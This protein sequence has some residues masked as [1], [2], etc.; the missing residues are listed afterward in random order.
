MDKASPLFVGD[1]L[2]QNHS[3]CVLLRPGRKVGKQRFIPLAGECGPRECRN[4]VVV[5][6]IFKIK[7]ETRRRQDILASGCA[8]LD[9]DVLHLFFCHDGEIGGKRPG[10]C[11]PNQ[12][13]GV[14]FVIEGKLHRQGR[15]V[16]F[17]IIEIGLEIRKRR[18]EPCGK[19]HHFES[20]V[21][22]PFLI[23][24]AKDPPHRF[25]VV[26]IH[27]VIGIFKRDPPRH[28]SDD[29]FPL[30]CISQNNRAA[31]FIEGRNAKS[32]DGGCAG[33]LFCL[34]DL[35]FHGQTM[36]V[37]PKAADH[38][39]PFHRLVAE[40][41]IFDRPRQNVAIV[42]QSSCE[43]RPVVKGKV[44]LVFPF[45]QRFFENALL[46]PEVEDALFPF[47]DRFFLIRLKHRKNYSGFSAL[48]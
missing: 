28:A 5:F 15:I 16:D 4:D 39:V 9:F 40:D 3:E 43:G 36:A 24:L 10:C 42:R 34:L 14:R 6:P 12:K 45:F 13:R 35:V 46:L 2:L 25:H 41:N 8:V 21:N 17:F 11:R 1:R 37:P 20:F 26:K 29:L 27:R 33:Q 32:F 22:E 23:E 18:A 47:G 19:R 31:L 7:R 44:G 38:I 30:F 48:R